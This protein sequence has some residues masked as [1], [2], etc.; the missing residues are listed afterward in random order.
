MNPNDLP[1]EEKTPE[2]IPNTPPVYAPYQQ[3]SVRP[4]PYALDRSDRIF[5]AVLLVLSIF[6][7]S[8][9]VWGG[10]AA[11]FTAA[12]ILVFSAF[13][14]YLARK[15]TPLGFYPILCGVLSV[16]LSAVF[17]TTSDLLVR[18]CSVIV[19]ALTS[20]VW[21]C[22]L[23]EKNIP[24]RE[25]GLAERLINQYFKSLSRIPKSLRSLFVSDDPRVK[26]TSAILLGI[27]C[28][29]PLLCAVITLLMRSDAAFEGLIRHIFSDVGNT[30]AQIILALLLFPCFLSF[31][32]YTKKDED[33]T[34]ERHAFK[35]I[36]TAFIASFIGLLSV[37]YIAYLFSQLAYFFSA[38]SGILPDGYAFSYA[39]YA[40]RGFFELCGIAAI[41]MAVQYLTLLLSR[42]KDE[43]LPVI[44]RVLCTFVGVF[45]LLLI[46]TAIAK[47]VLYI[48]RYGVTVLRLGTSS[49]MIFMA[50][51]FIAML[52]RL[53][54]RRVRVLPVALATA[55]VILSVLGI[56]NI[57]HF[58][59]Q[60]NYNAYES[61]KI[62]KIDTDYLRQ[63]G[64]EGVPYL[65]KLTRCKDSEVAS[66]ACG[67]LCLEV[68]RLYKGEYREVGSKEYEFP[69]EYLIPKEKEFGAA[70]NFNIPRQKAYEQLDDFLSKN[71]TFLK[72]HVEERMQAFDTAN[73]IYY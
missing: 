42:K 32:F 35:G 41:N 17:V 18:F 30:A 55:A 27:A 23:G 63:L 22:A 48:R 3:K 54:L 9:G 72:D 46:A 19:M 45:T 70:S 20:T 31:G 24:D 33:E 6:S 53:Y 47:M 1:S 40:R 11:G 56:G 37:S 52:L 7:V 36:D 5:A 65:I 67:E 62:K 68:E 26:K 29:S 28:A 58:A 13:T 38:F 8:A 66:R 57:R 21:F 71:K 10:F 16:V 59:A 44:L 25:S 60:Y 34:K 43:K 39:D 64:D 49:F 73:D 2:T 69:L 51:V 12:F 14:F 15:G 50:V 4:A 61:G